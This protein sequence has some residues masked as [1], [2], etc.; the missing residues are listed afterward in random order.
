VHETVANA[1]LL[2]ATLHAAA[3]LFHHFML[4][5]RVLT[6]MLPGHR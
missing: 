3:A 1:L 4:K 6:R 2:L 5:D